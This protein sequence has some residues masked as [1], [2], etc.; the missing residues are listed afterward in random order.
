[1]LNSEIRKVDQKVAADN[2]FA[3]RWYFE[4]CQ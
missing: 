1:M 3:E 2:L 4:L